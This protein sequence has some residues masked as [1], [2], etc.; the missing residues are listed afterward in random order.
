MKST[1][2]KKQLETQQLVH[3]KGGNGW[4][5]VED[6]DSEYCRV[7]SVAKDLGAVAYLAAKSQLTP[8]RR[9]LVRGEGDVDILIDDKLLTALNAMREQLCSGSHVV[10]YA[11][12]VPA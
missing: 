6:I 10:R 11:H 2:T 1:L 4:G 7:I 3:H 8:E 9:E 5:M 12:I